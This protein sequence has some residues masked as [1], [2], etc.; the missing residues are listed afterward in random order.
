MAV[1]LPPRVVELLD[2]LNRAF[3][4]AAA[5]VSRAASAVSEAASTVGAAIRAGLSRHPKIAVGVAVALAVA[6]GVSFGSVLW[7][8]VTL[9]RGLPDQEAIRH[10]GQMN[11]ATAVFDRTD[12]LAFTIFQEQ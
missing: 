11:Q 5:A 10:I 7:L 1:P 9:S 12:R 4:Q 8:L 6:L 3:P 2:R